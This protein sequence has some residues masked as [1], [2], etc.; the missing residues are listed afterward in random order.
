[1][2]SV[3]VTTE[4][5]SL[6][7]I[8]GEVDSIQHCVIKF[9]NDLQQAVVFLLE[10]WFPPPMAI[11]LTVALSTINQTKLVVNF[12]FVYDFSTDVEIILHL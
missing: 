11:K 2:Q 3:S 4:V 9:V 5:V 6:N 8:L 7:L 10:L 12:D 1:V